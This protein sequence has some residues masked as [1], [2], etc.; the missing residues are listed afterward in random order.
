MTIGCGKLYIT[1]NR[2]EIGLCEVFT[3]TG[4]TGGCPSQSEAISRMVSLALRSGVALDE[5]IHQLQGIRCHSAIRR[6]DLVRGDKRAV[7]CPAAIGLVL[8]AVSKSLTPEADPA[9]AAVLAAPTP[10]N[11]IL[12]VFR[13]E[14]SSLAQGKC[15]EC[16]SKIEY[17]SG[18]VVCRTCGYS[19]CG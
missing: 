7:S 10:I 1:V 12:D 8:A 2:D 13:N 4:R 3:S 11:G 15:P 19:K 6:N 14:T 18:C 16:N 9:V 5:I 17:E